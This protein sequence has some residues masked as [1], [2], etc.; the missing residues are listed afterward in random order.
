M[1][2][3]LVIEDEDDLR[4]NIMNMLGFEGFDVIGA[5]NGAIGMDLARQHL[6]DIIVCDI[7][8]PAMD[9]YD[10]LLG[11]RSDPV[12]SVIPFI[13]L[14]AKAGRD[15]LRV[16]M[17][18]GADDYIAK[19]FS[20]SEL[21]SAIST[22]LERH[23]AIQV[24]YEQQLNSLRQ[25]IVHAL[26]PEL[27]AP[28]T[29]VIGYA[30]RIATQS[31]KLTSTQIA[32][33]AETILRSSERLHREI[34]NYLLYA[35][36][37]IM[38]IDP[39]RVIVARE[40]HLE[41]PDLVIA[42]SARRKA[43]EYD[44]ESDLHLE[45]EAADIRAARDTLTRIISEVCENAFQFSAA[46]LLVTVSAR[47]EHDRYV[48]RI[49]DQGPGIPPQVIERL[50]QPSHF[51]RQLNPFEHSGLGLIIVGHMATAHHGTLTV[52]NVPNAGVQI[53]IAFQ[54][55]P[56]DDSAAESQERTDKIF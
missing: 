32:T 20:Y 8:M 19:P 48:I 13:F 31:E 43:T 51:N 12:T 24:E 14:T 10:V 29:S 22:R 23:R 36:L 56:P 3:V 27:H 15:H 38:H 2:R 37:E 35:Q 49:T 6:P 30:E 45:L 46:G 16:G 41:R 34:E 53:T 4:D 7:M 52:E 5:E 50:T 25:A 1:S 21:L 54:L 26:P 33:M 9:G 28:L 11:L 44:R 42:A 17:E 40:R 39:E 18:L 55:E 47:V